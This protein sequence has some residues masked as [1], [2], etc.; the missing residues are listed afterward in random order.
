LIA[1]HTTGL[2]IARSRIVAG[3]AMDG[4]AGVEGIALTNATTVNGAAASI[5][6][7]CTLSSCSKGFGFDWVRTPG[8]AGGTNTCV[9][10]PG[11]VAQAGGAGGSGGLWQANAPDGV[12]YVWHVYESSA[13]FNADAGEKNRTGANGDNGTDGAVASVGAAAF[14]IT[15]FTPVNGIAGTDGAP[16]MGGA[17]GSGTAPSVGAETVSSNDVWR[18][19][20]GASGG[21]GGCPG[22][23]GTPGTG[24]GASIAALLFASPIV[25]D[26]SELVSGR[27]GNGGHGTFGSAPTAGG[28][29][30][31][32][33][34]LVAV[35]VAKDGGR[36]GTA[37]TSS[38]GSSGPSIG[39]AHTGTVPIV[40]N[41]TTFR[42]GAGGAALPARSRTDSFGNTKTIAATLAGNSLASFAF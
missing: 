21:A 27:G 32:G 10:A 39:I 31:A 1:D 6:N 29:A 38:N 7:V 24:G 25:F 2:T 18:G 26:G 17:G 9:G 15:G 20:G 28:H 8:V 41:G 23:A 30:G 14:S 22:L 4:A 5:S 19:W 42:P 11:H 40:Q 16:G 37:G 33:S 34:T 36:G 35:T 13:Q 12:R 3:D